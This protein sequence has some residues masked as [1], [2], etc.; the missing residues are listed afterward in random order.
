MKRTTV[1]STVW[2]PCCTVLSVT[3]PPY[4]HTSPPYCTALHC[5][6]LHC[7]ALHRNSLCCTATYSRQFSIETTILTSLTNGISPIHSLQTTFDNTSGFQHNFWAT[8]HIVCTCH[9]VCS[10][11]ALS[12]A[13]ES[14]HGAMPCHAL[15][16]TALHCTALH[17]KILGNLGNLGNLGPHLGPHL[18]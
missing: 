16:C 17:C 6:A 9:S 1:G 4:C 12:S 15:H 18:T 14:S 7:T 10:I 8:C 5:T 2:T 11:L 13:E 3:S